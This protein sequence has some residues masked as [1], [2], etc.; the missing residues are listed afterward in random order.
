MNKDVSE[1][2]V[3]VAPRRV[4]TQRYLLGLVAAVL[5]P[6]LAFSAF[7]LTRYSITE[8]A[9]YEREAVQIARHVALV[10]DSELTGFVSVLRGLATSSALARGDFAQFHAEVTG[11]VDGRDEIIVLRELGNRQI[12]NT[13]R[14]F[15][16]ELPP[17]VPIPPEDQ[18]TFAAGR[19]I[20]SNVY[21]SPISGEARIAVALPIMDGGAPRHVLAITFPTARIRDALL[22]A[23]PDGGWIIGVGDRAG[24]FVT[25]SARHEEVT[26]KPGVPDYLAKAVGTSGTFTSYNLQGTTLLAGYYRSDF[27]GWLYAANIPQAQVEA[28]L[29]QSLAVFA[30]LGTGALILSAFLAYLF[31]RGITDATTGLAQR[32]AALGEGRPVSPMSTPVAELALVGDALVSAAG[33]IEERTRELHSLLSRVPASVTFTYDL[34]ARQVFR[35]RFAAELMRLPETKPGSY[36][37]SV[38]DAPHVRVSRDGKP[39]DRSEMP[40]AR[41]MRGERVED[42]EYTYIFT[43]GTSR[44]LLTSAT[45]L[46]DEHGAIVGAV[47]ASLEIT[48]RKRMEEQRRLLIN[49]LNHRV[50]NTLA[51]VQSIAMHTLRGGDAIAA[52]RNALIDR[53]IA[54]SRVQDVLTRENWEGAELQEIVT[55][56]TNLYP[57]GRFIVSGPPAWLAPNWALTLALTF[58][59]LATNAAK[60]GALSGEH[61]TVALSW[62]IV[63]AE[64]LLRVRWEER[65]GPPVQPPTRTGFGTQLIRR[66]LSPETG[67]AVTIDYAAAGVVCVMEMPL[68]PRS[69]AKT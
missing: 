47:A 23:V 11:L 38:V 7:L 35:N 13:Q 8:R 17:A 5:I 37:T 33:A 62:E 57:G 20:V 67:G 52:A 66:S 51:T 15:G 65:G 69:A 3:D 12:L 45:T 68:P 18:A 36:T 31:G 21:A 19:P 64:P 9:R 63:E 42:E 56:L 16:T 39:L 59:E 43:D 44:T 53:I 14:P 60:Y 2:P 10:I 24:V 29:W 61:G 28:P 4:S 1:H 49:E 54:L 55:N 41:A 25:R 30:A 6:L 32:A 46:R 27:S 34:E 40:L 26:G 50:K 48:E 22:P 58:H